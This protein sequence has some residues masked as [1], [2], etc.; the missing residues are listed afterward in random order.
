MSR[1]LVKA[2]PPPK[3]TLGDML[4]AMALIFG[5]V[6]FVQAIAGALVG[7]C[8]WGAWNLVAVLL[9]GCPAIAWWQCWVLGV[10]VSLILSTLRVSTSPEMAPMSTPAEDDDA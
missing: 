10:G 5:L 8:V 6:I 9:F 2:P 3:H 4:G 1:A 7:V